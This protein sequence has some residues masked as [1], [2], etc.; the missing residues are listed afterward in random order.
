MSAQIIGCARVS[1]NEQDLATQLN[2]LTGLGVPEGLT[3][4]DHGVTGRNGTGRD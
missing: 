4:V 3:N 2:P 1:T